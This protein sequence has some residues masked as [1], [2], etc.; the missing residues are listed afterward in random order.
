VEIDLQDPLAS[1]KPVFSFGSGSLCLSI[2]ET[3]QFL[4]Q[5]IPTHRHA[6]VKEIGIGVDLGRDLPLLAFELRRDDPFQAPD[7]PTAAADS[8]DSG[9]KEK[10]KSNLESPKP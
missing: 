4:Q 3:A 8:A 9:E 5:V 1:K 7:I 2:T 6:G 10:E